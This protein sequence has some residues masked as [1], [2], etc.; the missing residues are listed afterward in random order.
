MRTPVGLQGSHCGSRP[1]QDLPRKPLPTPLYD[2]AWLVCE[3]LMRSQ[4]ALAVLVHRCC[5]V[6]GRWESCLS[7]VSHYGPSRGHNH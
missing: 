5:C 1:K 3:H 4:H 7:P 6:S 2:A